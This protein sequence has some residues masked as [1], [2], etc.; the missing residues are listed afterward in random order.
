MLLDLAC[1][2]SLA[3]SLCF[4]SRWAESPGEPV[5]TK[6]STFHHFGYDPAPKIS[7]TSTTLSIGSLVIA[8][9]I[10]L[11]NLSNS[12]YQKGW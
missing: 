3:G 4:F 12:T 6:I 8:D 9:I 2:Q 11:E 7:E 5:S 10:T 1:S